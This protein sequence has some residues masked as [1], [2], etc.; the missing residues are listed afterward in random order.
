MSQPAPGWYPD[1]AGSQRL[2]WWNGGECTVQFHDMPQQGAPVAQQ[3]PIAQA[4]GQY[5]PAT[6]AS[7]SLRRSVALVRVVSAQ[8]VQLSPFLLRG[9]PA[10]LFAHGDGDVH[11][12][13]IGGAI[14]V[15]HACLRI[16]HALVQQ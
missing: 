9:A 13:T 12:R 8:P 7:A 2:R 15:R 5:I 4:A 10:P 6:P 11:A 16:G 1:P 3:M 14:V